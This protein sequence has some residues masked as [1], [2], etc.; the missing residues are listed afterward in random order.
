MQRLQEHPFYG[1]LCGF[2]PN[3][4]PAGSTFY[5]FQDRLLQC[6]AP[7]LNH[8]CVLRRRSEQRKKGGTLH[9]KNHTTPHAQILDRLAER[10]L[11]QRPR[12]MFHYACDALHSGAG[13][14]RV[15][16]SQ[17]MYRKP[18]SSISTEKSIET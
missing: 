1:L 11:T 9:D 13:H 4:M 17:T 18:G 8:A 7:I 14:N 10:L 5:D 15:K 12:R 3:H 6:A 2:E 16:L